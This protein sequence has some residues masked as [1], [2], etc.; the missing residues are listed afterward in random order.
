MTDSDPGSA[1]PTGVTPAPDERP[2]LV[3]RIE[4]PPHMAESVDD[5]MPKHFDDSLDH[6]AVT[7]VASY[8]VAR[9]FDPATGL[10]WLLNGHGNRFI[11]Y[12]AD[13][14]DHLVEW[15]D[16]PIIRD[17]IEDGVDRESAFPQLDGEPFTG[18]IYA[19]SSVRKPLGADFPGPSMVFAE[20]FQVGAD[21][22][23]ELTAWLEGE[24]LDAVAALAGVLRVRTFR[25][26]LDVPARFPY[27]RYTSKGNHMLLAEFP[28]GDPLA[29]ARSEP[30]REVLADSARWDLRLPYVRRE[31]AVNHVLRDKSDAAATLEAR[32]TA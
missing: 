31:V 4:C 5:W 18:N 21:D 7:S 29:L 17:A 19:V 2:L 14:V 26:H 8:R 30:F 22:E 23:P 11:V 32:R 24:H 20:R 16:S 15:I 12:V 6:P 10:P 1:T 9:D 13:S 28:L 25:Q 27:T 3:C